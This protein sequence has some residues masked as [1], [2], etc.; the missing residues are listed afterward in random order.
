[1]RPRRPLGG[2]EFLAI[3]PDTDAEGAVIVAE[4]IRHAVEADAFYD[5][6]RF[7]SA[8][9][10]AA[11]HVRLQVTISLGVATA[12]RPVS[13]KPDEVVRRADS[14]L[15]EAKSTGRNRVA[16]AAPEEEPSA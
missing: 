12:V 11:E 6:P 1:M 2:E 13:P 3:L 5:V 10:A 7:P 4:R 15:Y 16:Y 14:A 8:E 9:A